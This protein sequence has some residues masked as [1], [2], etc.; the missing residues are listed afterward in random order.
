MDEGVIAAYFEGELDEETALARSGEGGG[1]E[2]TGDGART[3]NDE[4][5]FGTSTRKRPRSG[6][7]ARGQATLASTGRTGGTKALNDEDIFGSSKLREATGRPREALA[8][9]RPRRSAV[10][11]LV[12]ANA[13]RD[14][15]ALELR[16]ARPSVVH[17]A[18]EV[19]PRQSF[20]A[21][22]DRPTTHRGWKRTN[23]ETKP[24]VDT[25]S[26]EKSV[27]L[28]GLHSTSEPTQP[29]QGK[30]TAKVA[31]PVPAEPTRAKKHPEKTTYGLPRKA[32]EVPACFEDMDWRTTRE[33]ID[34]GRIPPL[35]ELCLRKIVASNH[36]L[37]DLGGMPDRYVF[38]F[39]EN[40]TPDT[41]RQVGRLN[42][43]NAKVCRET[44]HSSWSHGKGSLTPL[45]AT[46]SPLGVRWRMEQNLQV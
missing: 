39:L 30:S 33:V 15:P 34:H 24:R 31:R 5:I 2:A 19:L 25:V 8:A 40:A 22:A 45:W 17:Q 12:A 32:S 28:R 23:V 10:S 14:V 7:S 18:S 21:S 1:G 36:R 16:R 43:R 41:V 37:G 29:V 44:T 42:P 4:D 35:A 13:L 26:R 6:G 46:L 11:T 20:R 38:A 27:L 3:L 9:E